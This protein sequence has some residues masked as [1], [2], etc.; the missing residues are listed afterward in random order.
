MKYSFELSTAIPASQ[1]WPHYADVNKWFAWESDLEDI[2]LDGAFE[3]G[4]TGTMKLAGMPAMPFTL[5]SVIDER[6]FVDQTVIPHVGNVNFHHEL[7]PADDQTTIVKHSVKFIP[8]DREETVDDTK[9]VGGMFGDVP[10]AVF[11]L[12]EAAKRDA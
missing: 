8:F 7:V 12:I 9:M 1:L 6:E 4:G 10:E 2:T 5:L 3:T 11:R